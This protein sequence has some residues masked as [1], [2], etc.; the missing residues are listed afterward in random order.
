MAPK[1]AKWTK[2]SGRLE[3]SL[4]R[5]DKELRRLK[6]VEDF[7]Q[8]K[9]R[10]VRDQL[11][12]IGAGLSRASEGT[13]LK[14]AA[15]AAAQKE[16]ETATSLEAQAKRDRDMLTVQQGEHEAFVHTTQREGRE[17][18][19]Q[20]DRAAKKVKEHWTKVAVVTPRSPG[21]EDSGWTSESRD[22]VEE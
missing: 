7:H 16:L 2:E 5:M 4:R 22:M 17:M 14:R 3:Q 19:G 1:S 9:A 11:T 15:L 18:K 8:T 12:K 13:A 20:R 6:G 21:S 10:E